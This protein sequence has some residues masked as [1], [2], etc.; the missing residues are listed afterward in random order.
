MIE[1][2]QEM[3]LISSIVAVSLFLLIYIFFIK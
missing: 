2:F 3:G 1:L